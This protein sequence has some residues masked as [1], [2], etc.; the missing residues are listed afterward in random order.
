MSFYFYTN[1]AAG[2]NFTV[3]YTDDSSVL[4]KADNALIGKYAY[5]N[6]FPLGKILGNTYIGGTLISGGT[7]SGASWASDPVVLGKLSRYNPD[8]SLDVA[9]TYTVPMGMSIQAIK[10]ETLA[11]F[12]S[13]FVTSLEIKDAYNYFSNPP[14]GKTWSYIFTSVDKF[15]TAADMSL[16]GEPLYV[17]GEFFGNIISNYLLDGNKPSVAH[18][19][20]HWNADG[21]FDNSLVYTNA[22]G[23]TETGI[24][25]EGKILMDICV[26]NVTTNPM[27]FI[28]YLDYGAADGDYIYVKDNQVDF[29]TLDHTLYSALHMKRVKAKPGDLY[30]GNVEL[31]V[32]ATRLGTVIDNKE[33]L[34]EANGGLPF[35]NAVSG[36][37]EGDLIWTYLLN[38]KPNYTKKITAITLKPLVTFNVL[39]TTLTIRSTALAAKAIIASYASGNHLYF[40]DID[41]GEL[42]TCSLVNAKVNGITLFS[43]E[44]NSRKTLKMAEFV[45]EN[46]DL[47]LLA[48]IDTNGTD[49]IFGKAYDTNTWMPP[50]TLS[51][52]RI[53]S[54]G[55]AEL[56][57][58]NLYLYGITVKEGVNGLVGKRLIV[59]NIF[60]GIITRNTET[61]I[62]TLGSDL[63]KAGKVSESTLI[64]IYGIWLVETTDNIG[65]MPLCQA[66]QISLCEWPDYPHL[67]ISGCEFNTLYQYDKSSFKVYPNELDVYTRRDQIGLNSY[68]E[69][70][71]AH[72]LP[73]WAEHAHVDPAVGTFTLAESATMDLDKPAV[74]M[75]TMSLMSLAF[76]STGSAADMFRKFWQWGRIAVISH[77]SV[78]DQGM[79]TWLTQ[80]Y[81]ETYGY[82]NIPGRLEDILYNI[83]MEAPN[84]V[85]SKFALVPVNEVKFLGTFKPNQF[86]AT[87]TIVAFGDEMYIKLDLQG[88]TYVGPHNPSLT[89][90]VGNIVLM[91]DGS[92]KVFDGSTFIPYSNSGTPADNWQ[93]LTNKGYYVTGDTYVQ[94]DLVIDQTTGNIFVQKDVTV[95]GAPTMGTANGWLYLV[96]VLATITRQPLGKCG[97]FESAM[98]PTTFETYGAF[99]ECSSAGR[100]E[101]TAAIIEKCAPTALRDLNDRALQITDLFINGTVSQLYNPNTSLT[102]I[103]S[104][105]LLAAQVEVQ[106]AP[107]VTL[108]FGTLKNNQVTIAAELG[109][110]QTVVPKGVLRTAYLQIAQLNISQLPSYTDS[111]GNMFTDGT[112]VYLAD[113]VG[114]VRCIGNLVIATSAPSITT[115]TVWYDSNYGVYKVYSQT[116]GWHIVV[117]LAYSMPVTQLLQGSTIDKPALVAYN[118]LFYA[119]DENL[120]YQFNGVAWVDTGVSIVQATTNP[121][122]T[123]YWYNTDTKGI[124]YEQTQ[125]SNSWQLLSLYNGTVATQLLDY[126]AGFPG[127]LPDTA[128]LYNPNTTAIAYSAA[129]GSVR[130]EGQA[131]IVTTDVTLAT[132]TFGNDTFLINPVT[133]EAL[134]VPSGELVG[135][136]LTNGFILS[137]LLQII[138]M[139]TTDMLAIQDM[140]SIVTPIVTLDTGNLYILDNTN[141]IQIVGKVVVS[142]VAP[143]D[144]SV[145]WYDL[146]DNTYKVYDSGSSWKLLTHYG[147]GGI[148]MQFRRGAKADLPSSAASGEPLITLDT[149]ELYIGTGAG[150]PLKKISDVLVSKTEPA[151]ADRN[152]VWF[153]QNAN[154]AK[155][156]KNGSWQVVATPANVD[157]GTF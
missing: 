34:V 151:I 110:Q 39:G 91:L 121:A 58:S 96:N 89:Y 7:S 72:K 136:S 109:I 66:S 16:S 130:A 108:E 43:Y 124:Y 5:I 126:A 8:G 12:A 107:R 156:Y 40:D 60:I 153:D 105:D 30:A 51:L 150:N 75:Y 103:G 31:Y 21:T 44:F 56:I 50:K 52:N 138:Q 102:H 2:D 4:L 10:I 77:D 97:V 14:E 71:Y 117:D 128:L 36:W 38:E 112:K 62:Y 29:S 57:K 114:L 17:N 149:G 145:I 28:D 83:A 147:I 74:A 104:T 129:T 82:Q 18:N 86:Y 80:I 48:L 120:L 111:I 69:R 37:A 116:N 125:N 33:T 100:L 113:Q 41:L 55:S 3:L 15:L 88:E 132:A 85:F 119:V 6:G 64:T 143:E 115:N 141:N 54:V 59:N 146:R 154:I 135:K 144:L 49:Y 148:T 63:V 26:E 73:G 122:N 42:T 9:G 78:R 1:I 106:I 27:S 94:Y 25:V 90:S 87:N 152:K 20:A 24:S 45:I 68:T 98:A 101:F 140:I 131:V 23:N 81:G 65:R 139:T 92:F 32:G 19:I 70:F 13:D 133:R 157:Y 127:W 79:Q 123:N 61:V 142:P 47:S 134:F 53:G 93:I 155:V 67:T 84:Q 118:T 95:T 35:S 76:N 46:A 99:L 22:A 11:R 137:N